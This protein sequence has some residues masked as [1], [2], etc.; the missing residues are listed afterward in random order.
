[1]AQGSLGWW[2]QWLGSCKCECDFKGFPF[3]LFS[4]IGTG[5][6]TGTVGAWERGEK[7]HDLAHLAHL[8]FIQSMCSE[9]IH[10]GKSVLYTERIS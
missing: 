2:G 9:S 4:R 6:G 1:M 3:F 5:T 8:H 10:F 7:V